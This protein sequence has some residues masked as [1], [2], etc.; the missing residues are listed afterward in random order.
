[1]TSTPS[2]E[3]SSLPT[4]DSNETKLHPILNYADADV[5]LSSEGGTLFR[6]H[7]IT[8]KFTSGY[9]RS[10]LSDPSSGP[11][12]KQ[13]CLITDKPTTCDAPLERVLLMISGL[14]TDPWAS[15]D[16]AEAAANIMSY[17]DTPGPLSLLRAS[18]LRSAHTT[19]WACSEVR[20]GRCSTERCG[21]F[22]AF[23]PP[24]WR[25]GDRGAVGATA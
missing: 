2:S 18:L 11:Q 25:F 20:M 22:F 19:P 7:S 1:M 6:L 12:P 13:R 16:E 17:L 24:L 8:L 5:V 21:G 14:P 9:F 15:F 23:E 4:A 10:I 3:P